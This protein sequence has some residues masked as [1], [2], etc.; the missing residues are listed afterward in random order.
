[1]V[2][3]ISGECRGLLQGHWTETACKSLGEL[4]AVLIE[5][6]RCRMLVESSRIR[7]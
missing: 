3:F 5:G 1:M 4:A 7:G 6:R 2:L